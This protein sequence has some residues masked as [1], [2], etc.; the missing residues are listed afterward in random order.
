MEFEIN[1]RRSN[2]ED[3]SKQTPGDRLM[4]LAGSEPYLLQAEK[5]IGDGLAH[6][7]RQWVLHGN[8]ALPKT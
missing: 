8:V 4:S 3:D 7:I 2:Q 1:S 5:G 6:D